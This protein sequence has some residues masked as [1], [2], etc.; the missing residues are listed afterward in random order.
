MRY[1][2][3]HSCEIRQQLLKEGGRHVKERGMH[4]AG[5]DGI[6][7]RVGLSGAALYTHFTSK[8]DFLGA[9]LLEELVATAQRFLAAQGSIEEALAQYMSLAHARKVATGCPLPALIADVSRGDRVVQRAFER[10]LAQIAEALAQKLKDPSQAM[11]VLASAVGGVALARALPNDEQAE[12]VLTS[13]RELIA[14]GLKSKKAK[15]SRAKV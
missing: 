7:K 5:V 9:V 15:A 2:K 8:Q 6:A 13:T 3:E 11:A 12:A 1:S 14:R 4:G 10:G